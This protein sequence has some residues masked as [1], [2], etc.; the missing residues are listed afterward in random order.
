MVSQEDLA[1]TGFQ[2]HFNSYVHLHSA[3]QTQ[4]NSPN[5]VCPLTRHLRGE[6]MAH[7]YGG[8]ELR[9]SNLYCLCPI[10]YILMHHAPDNLNEVRK[11][12]SK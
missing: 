4:S 11:Q 1:E 2:D 5:P 3:Y 10:D 12:H 9:K 7:P 8:N 6:I